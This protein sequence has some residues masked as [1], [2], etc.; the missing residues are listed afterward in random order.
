MDKLD[1]KQVAIKYGVSHFM[2][3]SNTVYMLF[4]NL[5]IV[6]CFSSMSRRYLFLMVIYIFPLPVTRVTDIIDSTR[7]TEPAGHIFFF[8]FADRPELST[9]PIKTSNSQH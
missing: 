2:S 8:F 7:L 6:I 5:K 4:V 9:L 1:K 3:V